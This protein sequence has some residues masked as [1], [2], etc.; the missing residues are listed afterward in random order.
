MKTRTLHTIAMVGALALAACASARPRPT[1][2]ELRARANAGD[3][4]A[5]QTVAFAE[6]FAP[7]G[8]SQHARGALARALAETPNAPRLLFA[9][10]VEREVHGDPEAALD[11][12]LRALR[13]TATS[14]DP[15]APHVAE[16]VAQ[17]LVGMRDAVTGMRERI[18]AD[19][20]AALQ[21]PG[22]PMPARAEV[23]D[24]LVGLA[25][26]RGDAAAAREIAERAGCITRWRVAGPFGPRELLG[27]DDAPAVAPAAP[28]AAS[29][30][31]G[32][33]RGVRPT[34]DATARGCSVRLGGG[35]V[36]Q[37]GTS[38]AKAEISVRSAGRH[39][40]RIDTPN[41]VAL[42][43]DGRSELRI[44]RRTR[45]Y[46]RV[47]HL[48]IDLTAGTHTITLGL[49]S[50]HPNPVAAIAIAP[51]HPRDRIAVE[52]P[53]TP[54]ASTGFERVLRSAIATSRGDL[55]GGREPLAR[56][57]RAGRVSPLV[58]I[59]R[60]NVLGADA[61]VPEDARADGVRRLLARASRL[62]PDLWYPRVR[63][64]QMAARNGRVKEALAQLREAHARWP[65]VPAVGIA[66][67]DLLNERSWHAEAD[68]VIARLRRLVPDA[69]DVLSREIDALRRR[70]RE[71]QAGERIESLM[72]CEAESNGRFGI[73]L[74]QR[75]WDDAA[76]ELARLEALDPSEG[77]YGWILAAIE[78]AK[79]RGD[80]AELDA[81]IGELLDRYP[82]AERGALERLD[83]AL[84]NG[85]G[86][87][88]RRE[89]ES[90][91]AN[92]PA[93]LAALHRLV[94]IA[95][96]EHVL[97]R[98]RRDGAQAIAAF[99]RSGR[100]YDGPQVLIFDYLATRLFEDGSSIEVVHTIHKAQ[101]NEAVDAL[102]EVHVPE[103]ARVLTLRVIKPDGR[104]L[105]PD[106][107]A[108]KDTLSLPSVAAGDY[109]EFEYLQQHDPPDGLPGGYVGE[110][111]YFESF[112]IPFDVSEMVVLLPERMAYALDPRGPAPELAERI[113]NGLRILRWKVEHS[114]PLS[115][116]P[117]AV[118]P[119]E[120]I[121][122]VRIGVGASWSA[123]VDGIR[124]VLVDRDVADPEIAAL[125]EHIVGNAAPEDHRLRAERLYAWVLE[126]VENSDDMFSQAAVMLRARTGNR[127]RVLRY[128]L[129]LVGVPARLALAR[130]LTAD[131]T[132]SEVADGDTYEHLLVVVG[133]EPSLTWLYTVERWAPFGYV[134]PHLR[135]QPAL[136]LAQGAPRRTVPVAED[137]ADR[138][139]LEVDVALDAD[140][141]ARFEVVEEVRGA[142]A[143]A[144]REQ[145]ES[146]PPAELDRRFEEEYVARLVP[147]ATLSRVK[148]SGRE[149]HLPAIRLEYAFA[150]RALG[151]E[152]RGGR[153]L[154]PLLATELAQ[155][156]ARAAERT[157][158]QLVAGALDI[159]VTLRLRF[160]AGARRPPLP[161][162]VKL[163]AALGK[164]PSYARNH[165]WDGDALVIER[166]V[167]MPAMRIAPNEYGAFARFCREADAAEAR[168][169]VWSAGP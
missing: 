117:D 31:L 124:D 86:E 147:G 79:N 152:V 40:L 158:L 43:V 82:R 17:S 129:D 83:R 161:Q 164:R 3:L 99:E 68:V 93:A 84:A 12:Y 151:R 5:Q 138:R 140:G 7:G 111:F 156:Y 73:L 120:Y 126:N 34:R 92:E 89:L 39:T 70:K 90:A 169:L 62:D 19:A 21:A 96:G 78:L 97:E 109:V 114:V 46:P 53:F 139:V 18:T 48:P 57:A 6:L 61:L 157:T 55:V 103:G 41:S 149:Q 60:A 52:L 107:I 28:L 24:L 11:L 167:R 128:L 110:R 141:S 134:P 13:A 29:Y 85:R 10:G 33:G 143:V 63:L 160:P 115:P 26:R 154:P 15:V 159:D 142:G 74:R 133:N 168:E 56:I 23:A 132:A 80:A 45:L 155:G 64:A 71:R 16:I 67:A 166:S 121:P 1:L 100:H 137:G 119:R 130:S 112:E 27:F 116:E 125:A 42:F 2:D 122:S 77:R 4:Q 59:Q 148:I 75:R 66:L 88:A 113:E 105:E 98:W 35:P 22:L 153:A 69:C 108:G 50:R 123:F 150:V 44:D 101:S 25:F 20:R 131:H 94:P 36:A 54:D 8:D 127:A 76:R 58:L 9:A 135:G 118:N 144:W 65:D 146:L 72:A 104:R 163:V 106:A 38:W 47:L 32:P 165:R 51:E 91:L 95:R 162:D 87:D 102:A 14:D 81:R 145:L 37:G 49:T 136:L 30:D